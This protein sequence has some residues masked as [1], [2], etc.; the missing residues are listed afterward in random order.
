MMTLKEYHAALHF[1]E[2]AAL[3]RSLHVEAAD[4]PAG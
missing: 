3:E 1:D 4:A 2:L